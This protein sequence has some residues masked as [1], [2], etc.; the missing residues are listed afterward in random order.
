MLTNQN[1]AERSFQQLPITSLI[2][3]SIPSTITSLSPYNPPP[4]LTT[5]DLIHLLCELDQLAL[6]VVS[7]TVPSE[8][9]LGLDQLVSGLHQEALHRGEAAAQGPRL[10]FKLQL[11]DEQ[12]GRASL[13]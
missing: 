2:A 11:W 6:V 3:H 8:E 7:G 1:P 12:H 13:E 5:T 9:R 10:H 4:P